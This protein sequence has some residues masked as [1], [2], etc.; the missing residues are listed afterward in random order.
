MASGKTTFGRAAAE[1]IGWRFVDLD[2]RIAAR[3]GTPA[4]IFAAGGEARFREIETEMLGEALQDDENT[5]L[6]LGGG[7]V[8][9]DENLQLIRSRAKLIWLDTAYDII[10]SELDNADRPVLKGRT[11]AQIRALYD[12]RRPRYAAAA[13]L[14]FPIRTTDYEQVIADLAQTILQA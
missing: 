9:R 10:L 5:V 14:T 13:D 3:Y 12:D 7:T 1:R 2:E 4:E 8:L 6:A 11:P